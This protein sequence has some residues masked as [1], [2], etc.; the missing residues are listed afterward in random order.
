MTELKQDPL[1]WGAPAP[2]V[3]RG[4]AEIQA[5]AARGRSLPPVDRWNPPFC[6]DLDIRIGVDGTWHYLGSPI[7][8]PALVRLFAS[9]LRRDEDG[10]YYLVTP[11]ERVGIRVD[12]APFT[13]VRLDCVGE[14]HDRQLEFT[15]NVGDIIVA[16]E[17]NPLR[18]LT[19]PVD[20]TPRPY[21]R[22]RGLLDALVS[23][24]V[25]YDLVSLAETRDTPTGRVL[26]VV[27]QRAF[28]PLGPV[29]P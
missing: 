28:F 3:L 12:D 2:D 11:V 9:I 16:G 29:D 5:E 18:V 25:F 21:L 20:A 8:R 4:L 17:G 13:A 10:K 14:G 24:S 15:T 7:G 1:H 26:G 6:G 22:V 19:N 23:R 27:S